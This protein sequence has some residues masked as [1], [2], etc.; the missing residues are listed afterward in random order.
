M[1]IGITIHL[2]SWLDMI[3]RQRGHFIETNYGQHD[4]L[5]VLKAFYPSIEP[6]RSI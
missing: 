6:N 2:A 5:A 3:V 4:T 1:G